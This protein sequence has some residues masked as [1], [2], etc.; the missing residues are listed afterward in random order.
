MHASQ[1]ITIS[2]LVNE[3]VISYGS[4]QTI[5]TELQLRWD[6]T[7]WMLNHNNAASH[8]AMTVQQFLAG[9]KMAL[10]LQPPHSG[11]CEFW[12]FPTVKMG[13]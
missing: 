13:L 4:A 6:E 3:T 8:T 7:R 11:H 5:L 1:Q 10:W 9:K 2:E 12:L